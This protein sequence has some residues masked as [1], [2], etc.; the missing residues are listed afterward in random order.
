LVRKLP[1]VY[2]T[3]TP[4]AGSTLFSFLANRHPYLGTVGEMTG[5]I[6]SSDPDSYTCSC[7]QRIR[8]CPFWH[9]VGRRMEAKGF[10]F[11][12]GDFD[13]RL[14]LGK[15]RLAQRV[16][17]GPLGSTALEDTRDAIVRLSSRLRRR[18]E[19]LLARNK[20][21]ASSI[22]EASGKTVFFDASKSAD[23]IRHFS[24]DQ[25]LDF[26]VVHLVRD[27]RGFSCSRRKNKG[28][29]DLGKLVHRWMQAN[30]NIE[31]QLRRLPP[32]RWIRIRYEDL[33][34]TTLE[35][36]NRFFAF[37]GLPPVEPAS[38]SLPT[39]HH[40]VGNRMR[41]ANFSSV[42]LDESWRRLL[43]PAEHDSIASQAA[44][45]QTRYGYKP[46]DRSDLAAECK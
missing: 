21:L 41:L 31:R 3:S 6:E 44:R 8:S 33:C 38:A 2:L 23:V 27:V 7:G 34:A 18:L 24:R 16:L 4:F 12:P 29:T 26:R 46:M 28:E 19:Y 9:D 20:A 36:L 17:N 32:D 15:G 42:H 10:P 1:F 30:K 5:L 22:L 43:T 14:R 35:T 13:T 11:D 37:C 45:M 40:I 39:E 25:D